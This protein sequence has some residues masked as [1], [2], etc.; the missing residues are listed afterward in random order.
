MVN[1]DP[2][3]PS[4]CAAVTDRHNTR[5]P[6]Q[7]PSVI[8]D[9][10]TSF[11]SQSANASDFSARLRTLLAGRELSWLSRQT[12]ISLSTLSDYTRGVIPRA[13]KAVSIA[14]A[15]G[16]SVEELIAG[17]GLAMRP[18]DSDPGMRLLPL[19]SFQ[20]LAT[21]R[22]KVAQ[23]GFNVPLVWL[24]RPACTGCDPWCVSLTDGLPDIAEQGDILLCCDAELPLVD[25]RNYLFM[26]GGRQLIRRVSLHPD[27]M[28]LI[29]TDR[30]TP[31]LLLPADADGGQEQINAIGHVIGVI[32]CSNR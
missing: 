20:E 18:R 3:R 24:Q 8:S 32:H 31:P 11:R 23:R 6:K 2:T 13:D 7:T 19:Y 9:I 12:G 15:L 16:S 30:H 21:G 17:A 1:S 26:L 29:S 10:S 27:G 28:L 22:P 25:N 5:S 14:A 4:G